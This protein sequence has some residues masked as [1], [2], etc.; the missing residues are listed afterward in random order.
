M[1]PPPPPMKSMF[2]SI[3]RRIMHVIILFFHGELDENG[4]I[5][6]QSDQ[7]RLGRREQHSGGLQQ[8]KT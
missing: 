4:F 7:L 1:I 2:P 5:P 8:N 6:I 3:Y